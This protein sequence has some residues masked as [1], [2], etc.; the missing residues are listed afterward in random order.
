[1]RGWLL[2]VLF[3]IPSV[4]SA[5]SLETGTTVEDMQVEYDRHRRSQATTIELRNAPVR[6]AEGLEGIQAELKALR[7]E[8]VLL[9]QLLNQLLVKPVEPV[10][11]VPTRK[12]W[13]QVRM[14]IQ[15]E[16]MIDDGY[17]LVE[18]PI[19]SKVTR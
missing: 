10:Q 6:Q 8:L 1:M 14:P 16:G 17:E 2:A 18:E 15:I 3:L 4:V 11:A 7:Q 19:R 13:K 12:V 5:Q 9:R